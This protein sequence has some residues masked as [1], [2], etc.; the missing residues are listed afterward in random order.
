MVNLLHKHL[1]EKLPVR[2]K[3]IWSCYM[4]RFLAYGDIMYKIKR[5]PGQNLF[6][7]FKACH[8]TCNL[9]TEVETRSSFKDPQFVLTKLQFKPICPVFLSTPLSEFFLVY[10]WTSGELSQKFGGV[11]LGGS[12]GGFDTWDWG[13]LDTTDLLSTPVCAAKKV[14][15]K[16]DK[17][18]I[19]YTKGR[20]QI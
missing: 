7:L 1:D 11:F 14:R 18:F 4:L 2:D 19:F 20:E 15:Q 3:T 8:V 17:L 10:L 16:L 6:F 12:L 5:P 13:K 9:Q